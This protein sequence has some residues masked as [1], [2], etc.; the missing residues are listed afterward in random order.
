MAHY[1]RE[2]FLLACLISAL[3]GGAKTAART[4]DRQIAQQRNPWRSQGEATGYSPEDRRAFHQIAQPTTET[5]ESRVVA[6]TYL[7]CNLQTLALAYAVGPDITRTLETLELKRDSEIGVMI[8]NLKN[9][10][11]PEGQDWLKR[12]E[13][14]SD[15][16]RSRLPSLC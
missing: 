14:L 13:V 8:R 15:G 12:L 10:G 3:E 5:H 7:N 2:T 11:Q 6:A 9:V 1:R 16:F 4:E